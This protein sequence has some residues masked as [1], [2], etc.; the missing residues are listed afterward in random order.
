LSLLACQ[1][2]NDEPQH[3]AA[4]LVAAM[5]KRLAVFPGLQF[6]FSQVIQDNV[7][8]AIPGVKGEIAIKIFGEDLKILQEKANQVTHI[9]R[10]IEGAT[11]QL[12]RAGRQRGVMVCGLASAKIFY[13]Q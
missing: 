5:Q 7:E 11:D 4:A 1:S 8:G 3:Q 13:F 10:S 12:R 6:N 9:L 2:Q